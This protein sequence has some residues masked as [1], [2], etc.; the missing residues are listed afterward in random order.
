MPPVSNVFHSCPQLQDHLSSLRGDQSQ[1]GQQMRGGSDSPDFSS[2]SSR[3]DTTD[4]CVSNSTHPRFL[5]ALI[6]LRGFVRPVPIA[7][8]VP[9]Q[10]GERVRESRWRFGRDE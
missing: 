4:F 5:D 8:A 1:S 2:S 9:P 10:P 3:S 6:L 7:L